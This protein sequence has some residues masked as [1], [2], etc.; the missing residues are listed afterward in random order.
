MQ[1]LFHAFASGVLGESERRGRG[2]RDQVRAG[3]D[4]RQG[5][6]STA[7]ATATSRRRPARRY[8]VGRADGL[9]Q[10]MTL[11]F[12]MAQFEPRRV[13]GVRAARTRSSGAACTACGTWC[14]RRPQAGELKLPREDIL[15]FATPH[16][17]EVSVNSTRVTRVLGT[18]V[19]DLSYA[20]WK[21]RRQMRQIAAF[22]RAVRAGL[23]GVLRRAERRQRRR[24]RDAPHPRRL[25][26]HRRRR[27]Q[28]AQVRR[29]DRARRVSGRHPQPERHRHRAQA[30]AAGRGLRHP[31]ALPAAA[32]APRTCSSPGAASP[33]RT[34][35]TRPIA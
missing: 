27:P 31:A 22:L 2:V 7:P 6:R 33:A 9:V 1:F 13:R 21:S 30:P 4:P 5:R 34:R 14:A 18:D 19:W 16:E 26:A 17:G 25:P 12:R 11:M 32:A 24:A 20:E 29:R 3:R 28:R 23:R 15:F 8:E 10:P 35:R